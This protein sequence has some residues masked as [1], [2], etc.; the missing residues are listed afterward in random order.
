MHPRPASVLLAFALLSCSSSPPTESRPQ[1]PVL[2]TASSLTPGTPAK[3]T[4]AA[5]ANETSV[6]V[7]GVT[8][9][10]TAASDTTLTFTM[11]T[12]RPCD[13][14]GRRVA[15]ALPR[16]AGAAI[17]AEL[18]LRTTLSLEPGES[19]V[20]TD[21]A[22]SGCLQ[23][24][25][26]DAD[27]V[28]SAL[29]RSPSP[30]EQP[31]LLAT[32]TL[33]TATDPA[34][35]AI[36]PIKVSPRV[37]DAATTPAARFDPAPGSELP[38]PAPYALAPRLFDAAY[39]T[40][41]P[42]D[43]ILFVDW[44][45]VSSC[46]V[47]AA[48]APSYP[49]V[50]AAV[51][52]TTIIAVDLRLGSAGDYLATGG[53]AFLEAAARIA[54]PLMIPTMRRV[55]DPAFRAPPAAGGRHFHVVTALTDVAVST[56]GNTSKPQSACALAS[57]VVTTLHAAPNLAND[58][59]PRMLATEIIHE[60]A[61]NADEIT[62]RRHGRAGGSVGWMHE[63][64]AVNAEETAARVAVHEPT[65]ARL[66]RLGAGTPF[67]AGTTNSDWG[68]YP[69]RSPWT[70]GGAY[71][72]GAALVSYAREL[73][74]EASLDAPAPRLFLTLLAGDRWTLEGLAVA[75]GVSAGFLHDAW[76]LADATDDLGPAT[77][78]HSQLRSWDDAERVNGNEGP[79]GGSPPEMR[80]SRSF[81]RTGTRR[82]VPLAAAPGS[83]AAAYL[84]A[85]GAS[86][87]TVQLVVPPGA[88]TGVRITRTR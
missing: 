7:D 75:L 55:F 56:D 84:F 53:R 48:A 4:G 17:Q 30:A 80:P 12:L 52:G 16:A 64:W 5:L 44:Q 77:E 2:F 59:G 72:Q 46:G 45:R 88:S 83:Y 24:P 82:T 76:A 42:G 1:Q 67:R 86:G 35:P 28:V 71:K 37:A 74:G 87:L 61:H 54:D 58:L 57:E 6:L 65:R 20:L 29:N 26:T 21:P 15:L 18:R 51:A 19:L 13:T 70:G 40:A 32:L 14:D 22:V 60:Y 3:V 41:Q 9:P 66:S 34:P 73:G 68:L 85:D 79:R 31:E 69:H 25:A 81:P 50:I 38:W 78:N 27:F 47:P 23:L 36:Q 8:V 62:G 63:A 11:P 10:A 33:W 43:T 49:A 39:A